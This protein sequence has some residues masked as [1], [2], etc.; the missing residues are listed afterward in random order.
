[1]RSLIVFNYKRLVTLLPLPQP[2]TLG[3]FYTLESKQRYLLLEKENRPE[4]ISSMFCPSLHFPLQLRSSS[5]PRGSCSWHIAH[6]QHNNVYL[7]SAGGGVLALRLG[8]NLIWMCLMCAWNSKCQPG[9]RWLGMCSETYCSSPRRPQSKDCVKFNSG[10]TL[11]ESSA[12][13]S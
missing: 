6:E 3:V 11:P 13:G 2:N 5:T 10:W 12:R 1:M 4:A 7:Q 8:R 9:G